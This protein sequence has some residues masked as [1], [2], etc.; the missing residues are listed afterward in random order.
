[1]NLRRE[2]DDHIAENRATS[3]GCLTSRIT[4]Y[5]PLPFQ[6]SVLISW[7]FT[8]YFIYCFIFDFGCLLC[9]WIM[10]YLMM[11]MFDYDYVPSYV[12]MSLDAFI[13]SMMVLF[14]TLIYG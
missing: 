10:W 7:I 13:D 11:M 8:T 3:E 4:S 9:F 2:V 5:L 6:P 12:W 14:Y 1:M